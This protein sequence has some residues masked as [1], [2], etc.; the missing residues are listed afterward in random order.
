M[1][2]HLAVGSVVGRKD[3]YNKL[4]ARPHLPCDRSR[5]RKRTHLHV[6]VR[7][8]LSY[9]RRMANIGKMVDGLLQRTEEQRASSVTM[10]TRSVHYT[11]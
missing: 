5:S 2:N 1:P 6:E 9:G 8:D 7:W 3:T 11:G 10:S 4:K